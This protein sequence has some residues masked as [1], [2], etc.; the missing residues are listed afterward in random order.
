MSSVAHLCGVCVFR[1]GYLGLDDL[2]LE[3]TDFLF[4]NNH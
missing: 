1:A 4:L 3:E 2:S